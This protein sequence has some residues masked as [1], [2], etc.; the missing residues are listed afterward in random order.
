MFVNRQKHVWSHLN[1]Q[2]FDHSSQVKS[3]LRYASEVSE[4]FENKKHFTCCQIPFNLCVPNLIHQTS[5]LIWKWWGRW[6][7][8][9]SVWAC[10]NPS[11]PAHSV[12]FP[13][14]GTLEN[15]SGTRSGFHWSL[16]T[17][18]LFSNQT[19]SPKTSVITSC[20]CTIFFYNALKAPDLA[21]VPGSDQ[22]RVTA[23]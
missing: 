12:H 6:L 2:I 15:T 1:T 14:S 11:V 9:W 4:A 8:M 20:S 16:R 17:P 22:W 13:F 21:D 10:C 3:D 5:D 23:G 18:T 19:L 7:H